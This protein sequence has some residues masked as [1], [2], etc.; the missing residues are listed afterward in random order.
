MS[1]LDPIFRRLL[2]LSPEE[3]GAI[4]APLPE[5]DRVELQHLLAADEEAGRAGSQFLRPIQLPETVVS[6]STAPSQ[7]IVP[8]SKPPQRIGDY[9]VLRELGRGAMGVVY[10]AQRISDGANVAIKLISPMAS[11]SQ[12]FSQMFQREAEILAS[13]QHKR[14][15]RCIEYGLHGDK[16][17][18]VMEYVRS[19]DLPSLLKEQ[20]RAKQIQIACGIA[21]Y[22]LS[23]LEYAH[24]QSIVHRDI[25]PSNIL[26]YT[27]GGRLKAKVADFGLAKNFESAGITTISCDGDTKGTVAYMAPEQFGNSRY[28]DPTADLYATGACLY[29]FLTG[30]GPYAKHDTG[31]PLSVMRAIQNHGP[32]PIQEVAPDIGTEL[33]EFIERSLAVNKDE[34]FQSAEKMRVSLEQISGVAC[35]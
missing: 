6:G 28:A 10:R 25:K 32:T 18:L 16:L 15:V 11:S 2:Q 3:R 5:A 17:F 20:S 21:G 9:R 7:Q 31:H 33:A 19:H 13:L 34:R 30:A 29:Y 14:I 4:L 35:D 27:D 1:N 23:A 24:G 26:A 8:E 12:K 22:V